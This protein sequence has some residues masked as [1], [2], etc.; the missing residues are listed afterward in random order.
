MRAR[1]APTGAPMDHLT[2][3]TASI[4]RTSTWLEIAT[5]TYLD[6]RHPNWVLAE[7]MGDVVFV[8]ARD[9]VLV[10]RERAEHIVRA[11]GQSAGLAVLEHVL[12]VPTPVKSTPLRAVR[13][14][15]Q[16]TAAEPRVMIEAAST[17]WRAACGWLG[18]AAGAAVFVAALA[19]PLDDPALMVALG[20]AV[21]SGWLVA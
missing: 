3:P 11:L 9:V 12:A 1:D 13:V 14:V 8:A 20:L 21:R 15:R 2:N 16:E 19:V 4:R 17:R 18:I 5:D 10:H 6:H 7:E